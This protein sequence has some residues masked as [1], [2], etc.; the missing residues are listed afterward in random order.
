MR[1]TLAVTGI[2]AIILSILAAGWIALGNGGSIELAQSRVMAMVQS[3]PA[4]NAGPDHAAQ[5]GRDIQPGRYKAIPD[6]HGR[7]GSNGGVAG[8]GRASGIVLSPDIT[9]DGVYADVWTGATLIPG[10]VRW[11]RVDSRDYAGRELE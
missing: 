6:A 10:G 5:A 3:G 11:V 7:D 8:A 2:V 1:K 9:S 4:T